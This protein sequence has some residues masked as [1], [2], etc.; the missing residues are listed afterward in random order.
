[1]ENLKYSDKYSTVQIDNGF[2]NHNGS[3]ILLVGKI[4]SGYITK[5]DLLVLKS[6]KT[7]PIIEVEI[8]P[9]QGIQDNTHFSITMP[10]EHENT[11]KWYQLYGS[12]MKILNNKLR[13]IK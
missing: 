9:F 12:T 6:G 4:C 5:G 2:H 13:Q 10:R 3:G 8:I 7:I 11:P 1:M